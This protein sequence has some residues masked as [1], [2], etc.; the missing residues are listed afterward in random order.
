MLLGNA[1]AIATGSWQFY[2][3]VHA[4]GLSPDWAFLMIAVGGTLGLVGFHTGSRLS[5]RIGRRRTLAWGS[6]LSTAAFVGYY[7]VPVPP[8]P[9][10]GIRADHWRQCR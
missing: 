9:R 4:L 5:D 7:W 8:G 3:V 1:S 6:V 10:A 2:H